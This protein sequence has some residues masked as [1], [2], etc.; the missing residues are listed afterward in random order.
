[1]K[2][3]YTLCVGL[4]LSLPIHAQL[5]G[6][7]FGEKEDPLIGANI[8]WENTSI[9]V[10]SSIQGDFD[11]ERIK[12]NNKLVVSY[13]GYKSD[14][15]SVFSDDKNLT[16]KLISAAQL[17]EVQVSGRQSGLVSF[18]STAIQTQEIS[19][20]ELCRAACCNLSES[21]ETNP[22]VDVSFS[23]AATGAK[24]IRLL[25]LPGI[26]VQMINENI[27]SFRGLGGMYGLSYVPGTWMDGIQISKGTSSVSNGYES[28]TGQIN[29]EYKKPQ[30]SDPLSFNLFAGSEGRFEANA[31]AATF[32]NKNLSTMLFLHG[33]KDTQHIDKNEDGFMDA[34]QVEQY[35]AFNRWNYTRDGY[36]AQF[37]AR[38]LY[39]ER[40]GGQTAPNGYKIGIETVRADAFMKH[41][42][43]LNEKKETSIGFIANGVFHRQ[44]SVYGIQTYNASQSSVYL[45]ALFQTH[46]TDDE[47]HFMKAGAGFQGDVYD[48]EWNSLTEQT[49]YAIP[50]VF[51]EYTLKL[52]DKWVVLAGLR[53]DYSK[54]EQLFYTP[55]LHLKYM[56]LEGVVMRFSVG[57]GYRTSNVLVENNNLLASSREFVIAPDLHQEAAWN[58]GVNTMF[59][60]PIGYRTL[61]VSAEYY[62]TSFENQLIIDLDAFINKVLFY[63]AAN[64]SYAH[65][66]QI[67]LST[68]LFDGFTIL[69]A[70]RYNDTKLVTAGKLQAKPL[71]STQRGLITASYKTS[72]E[73]W[74]VDLT[75]QLNGGGRMPTP[76]AVTPLWDETFNPYQVYNAQITRY[77]KQA[78]IYLGIENITNFTQSNAIINAGNPMSSTFDATMIWGPL[79][80][81]KIYVGLR[82]NLPKP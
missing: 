67:E 13:L 17:D 38:G 74:Q 46:L 26:Y 6:T 27:P 28:I 70:Y 32:V 82:Y 71:M 45:N 22:S 53:A 56:P 2:I 50:G 24:Q 23:D 1:M 60:I 8:Y 18:R 59:D 16:I 42:L 11:I 7:V 3:L 81:R 25:G 35:S 34:P 51:A 5:R 66:A 64:S 20:A 29:V 10:I 44:E 75:S 69:G 61:T 39:E 79:H 76:D 33:E 54:Q 19:S 65:N 30:R 80:G 78:S 77:F 4:L 52:L 48:E 15:L 12:N 31:D 40:K 73:R 37:G 9:G 49:T 21:F 68:E 55:R 57:K 41:G 36:T 63:N 47:A 58:T 62:Y 72:L 43:E 14:T